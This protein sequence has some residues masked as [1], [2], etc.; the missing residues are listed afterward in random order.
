MSFFQSV[1]VS[2]C[3]YVSFY[4]SVCLSVCLSFCLAVGLSVDL[5]YISVTVLLLIEIVDALLCAGLM[6]CCA[7]A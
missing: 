1:C 2:V 3:L 5:Y 7:R 6:L 4:L